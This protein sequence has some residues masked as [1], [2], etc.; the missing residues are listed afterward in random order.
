[1]EREK[2]RKYLSVRDVQDK[3]IYILKSREDV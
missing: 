2:P 1:M 3:D